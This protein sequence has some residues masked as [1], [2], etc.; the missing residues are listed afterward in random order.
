MVTHGA[1][2]VRGTYIMQQGY[3]KLFRQL[4]DNEIWTSEKFTDGQAWVDLILLANHTPGIIKKRG[5]RIDLKRGQIGWSEVQLSKRWRWSRG[6]VRRFLKYLDAEKMIKTVQ[7]TGQQNKFITTHIEIVNYETYQGDGTANGTLNSTANGQQTDS[8]RY[9]NNKE[10]NE[11][12]GKNDNKE[13]IYIVQLLNNLTG[14]TFRH[15]SDKT[16]RIIKARLSEGFTVEDF[17]TVINKKTEQW[18]NDPQMSKFLR[19]ETL[20]GNKFEGYLN[21]LK[22][23]NPKEEPYRYAEG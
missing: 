13:Q 22:C 9:R 15:S 12:N 6:K 4:Q 20:F 1:V 8:K 16:R 19:P 21:E 7:Q 3:I 17:E 23:D 2:P 11:N 10:E 14:K 5:I 18:K